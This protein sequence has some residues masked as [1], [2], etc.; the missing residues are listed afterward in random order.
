MTMGAGGFLVAVG[1]L[2]LM[3]RKCMRW[4]IKACMHMTHDFLHIRETD[5]SLKPI[6]EVL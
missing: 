6:K 2:D 1:I 5:I 4:S 3:S